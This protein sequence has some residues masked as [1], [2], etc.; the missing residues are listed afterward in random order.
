[1]TANISPRILLSFP[2]SGQWHQLGDSNMMLTAHCC[3]WMLRD[4]ARYPTPEK[5]DPERYIPG[6]DK[7][8]QTDPRC[9]SFGF[10]RRECPGIRLADTSLFISIVMS[11]A[12]F[13]IKP[14]VE[15]GV[16]VLPEV[17]M[18]PGTIWYV[19]SQADYTLPD[20]GVR[21]E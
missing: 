13:N 1:M 4:P 6:P 18:I 11:L 16:V 12:V 19:F 17:E 5:F 21:C 7:T 9:F 14:V 15:N 10:G 20:I 2:T 8:V 3:R